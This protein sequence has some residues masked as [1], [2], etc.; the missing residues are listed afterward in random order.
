[1]AARDRSMTQADQVRQL[2]DAIAAERQKIEDALEAIRDYADRLHA[3]AGDARQR[4]I[5]RG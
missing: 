3:A 1:M 2:V 4:L 5:G